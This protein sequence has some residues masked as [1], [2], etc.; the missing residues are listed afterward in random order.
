MENGVLSNFDLE[1]ADTGL[2]RQFGFTFPTSRF[3]GQVD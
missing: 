1:L 3:L 2:F